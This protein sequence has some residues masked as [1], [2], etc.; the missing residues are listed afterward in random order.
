MPSRVQGSRASGPAR[1]TSVG[2]ALLALLHCIRQQSFLALLFVLMARIYQHHSRDVFR[3][4]RSEH[5]NVESS[6]G[7]PYQDVWTGFACGVE[8]SFELVRDLLARARLR[9]RIAPAVARAVAEHT[10]ANLA[11]SGWTLIQP[12]PGT[13]LPL[14]KIT[15]GFPCPTQSRFSLTA[16]ACTDRPRWG[17][18]RASRH[19]PTR[20]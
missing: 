20:S 8:K 18:R 17:K 15:V 7:V 2:L 13:P 10:R 1:V 16:P 12:S 14:S 11:T 3:I 5:A 9:S 4:Q 19:I 6:E